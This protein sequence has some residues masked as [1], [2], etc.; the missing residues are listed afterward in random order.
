[1]RCSGRP[2]RL[3]DAPS[4]P[5]PEKVLGEERSVGW[6]NEERQA[7]VS[8]TVWHKE[9][10]YGEGRFEFQCGAERRCWRYLDYKDRLPVPD[11][12]ASALGRAWRS[13]TLDRSS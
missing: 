5:T 1:M 13:G 2:L 9:K 8:P 11:E 10:G 7:W 4:S 12:L 3:R 6:I